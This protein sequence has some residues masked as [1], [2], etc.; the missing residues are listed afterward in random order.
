MSERRI[1]V[2]DIATE[3]FDR[4]YALGVADQKRFLR[5]CHWYFVSDQAWSISHSVSFTALVQAIEVLLVVPSGTQTCGECGR[6]LGAGPTKLFAEFVKLH[7]PDTDGAMRRRLYSKRS[8]LT[9]GRTLLSADERSLSALSPLRVQE[10]RAHGELREI[11]RAVLINWLFGP[12][13]AK[14]RGVV[15]PRPVSSFMKSVRIG[16]QNDAGQ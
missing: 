1:D 12:G 4:Y 2:P 5:A 10:Q 6:T 16:G 14:V 15:T 7:A 13:N 8:A 11:T 9:H 3:F